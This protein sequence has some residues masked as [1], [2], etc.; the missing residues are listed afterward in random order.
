MAVLCV[1]TALLLVPGCARTVQDVTGPSNGI[2]SDPEID[3]QALAFGGAGG[4]PGTGA[5]YPLVVGNRWSY[6]AS[7]GTTVTDPGGSTFRDT[8]SF[9]ATRELVC[10]ATFGI[11]TYFAELQTIVHENGTSSG[12]E[13]YRQDAVG[14]YAS[15]GPPVFSCGPSTGTSTLANE[16]PAAD[17]LA[18]LAWAKRR[19]SESRMRERLL[20][21]EWSRQLLLQR[22]IREAAIA[23][24]ERPNPGAQPGALPGE[25]SLLHYPL[26]QGQRWTT[27]SGEDFVWRVVGR[28][29]VRTPAG[30]VSASKI[31]LLGPYLGR[32]DYAYVWYGR[33]GYVGLME[34]LSGKIVDESGN[35]SEISIETREILTG[36]QLPSP[37][38][39]R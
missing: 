4:G 17:V 10:S 33:V 36:Y 26:R 38:A 28:E 7:V 30:A 20:Q 15:S 25:A 24:V 35:P 9:T 19:P 3:P 12:W 13:H 37:L 1:V 2:V 5:F 29:I 18:K 21:E 32:N 31:Q 23:P 11:N 16:A 27:Y 6:Q 34:K 14:L 8:E 39:A 22:Q